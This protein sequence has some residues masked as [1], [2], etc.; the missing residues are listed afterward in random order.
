MPEY[1]NESKRRVKLGADTVAPMCKCL[2]VHQLLTVMRARALI[3]GHGKPNYFEYRKSAHSL[4]EDTSLISEMI[5][6]NISGRQNARQGASGK[7]IQ[8]MRME[9]RQK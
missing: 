4:E 6:E 9:N 3:K 7:R 2:F 1:G 5:H 8:R